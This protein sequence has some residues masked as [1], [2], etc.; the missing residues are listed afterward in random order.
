M[1]QTGY[2][3]K[4]QYYETDQMGVVHHSNYIRWFEEA[5]TDFLEKSG[6]SYAWMEEQGIV[7]PVLFVQAEYKAMVHYG[8]DVLII[9]AVKEFNG[10]KLGLS[11]E[12]RN[13]RT[14]ERTTTGTSGH[15]FLGRDHKP[16]RLKKEFPQVYGMF[17]EKLAADVSL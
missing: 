10:V 7:I 14:G 9:P 11:Y 6:F 15:C 1:E 8:E 2:R 17:M 4:V 12:V 16:L 13:A 3:H 5:R